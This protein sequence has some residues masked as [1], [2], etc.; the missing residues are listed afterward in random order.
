MENFYRM[1]NN[2]FFLSYFFRFSYFPN[3][4]IYDC[5]LI[6]QFPSKKKYRKIQMDFCYEGNFIMEM[7]LLKRQ[8]KM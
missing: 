1:M 5:C 6:M 4:F 8:Q 2:K 3:T 7:T